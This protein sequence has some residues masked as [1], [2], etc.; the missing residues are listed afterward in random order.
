MRYYKDEILRAKALRMTK[1]VPFAKAKVFF[2]AKHKVLRT[3]ALRM[4][5]CVPFAKA[6]GFF[7]Q[8]KD[9]DKWG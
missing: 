1:C 3:K 4:T 8:K 7:M 6:K 9:S 5:K 2:Y